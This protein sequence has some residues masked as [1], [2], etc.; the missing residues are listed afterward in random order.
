[1]NELLCP[2]LHTGKEHGR[3]LESSSHIPVAFSAGENQTR[4]RAAFFLSLRNE[5]VSSLRG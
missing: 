5:T 2:A 1:M 3:A 4:I